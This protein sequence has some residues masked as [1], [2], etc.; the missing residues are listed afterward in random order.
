MDK[1]NKDQSVLR[2]IIIE[3]LVNALVLSL[4]IFVGLK[5][6]SLAILGDAFHSL[7][8]VINNVIAWIVIR[9][10]SQ[11]A[12]REHPYGHR[13]FETL[14]VFGLATLL[15]VVAFELVIHSFRNMT[16]EVVSE[17]WGLALMIGVL[18]INILLAWW[19]RRWAHRLDSE[20][21]LAD[22]SHTFGDVLTTLVVIVGWQLSALGYFWLDRITALVVAGMILYLAYKLFQR[23]VPVLVDQMAIEP[24]LLTKEIKTVAGVQSVLS[25]RSRWIGPHKAVDMTITVDSGLSSKDSHEIADRIEMHLKQELGVTDISIHIEHED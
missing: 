9:L 3:G 5:T 2:I 15:S 23:S 1:L 12:D 8:D 17:P 19:Q 4:K 13:K 25:V 6:G 14:A 18:F 20:I 11:P 16:S 10:S 21:L 7:V 24:E 22:A